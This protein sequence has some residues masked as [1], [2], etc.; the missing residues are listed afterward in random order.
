MENGPQTQFCQEIMLEQVGEGGEGGE[1]KTKQA[2]RIDTER[3]R[4]DVYFEAH[5]RGIPNAAKICLPVP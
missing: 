3:E 5:V 4:Y 2:Y 1:G